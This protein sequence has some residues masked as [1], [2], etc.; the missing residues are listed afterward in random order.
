MYKSFACIVVIFTIALL[1]CNSTPDTVAV[2][3]HG[4]LYYIC[5]VEADEEYGY[6]NI[7]VQIKKFDEEGEVVLL[8]PGQVQLDN[9]PLLLDSARL[10]G[11][12]Y[13]IRKSIE[14]FTNKHTL[15]ITR[16]NGKKYS[17]TFEWSPLLLDV[18]LSGAVTRGSLILPLRGVKENDQI[19]LNLID[20]SFRTPDINDAFLVHNGQIQV[21][22]EVLSKVANGPVTLELHKENEQ[23]TDDTSNIKGVIQSI[24]SLRREFDLID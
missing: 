7:W 10:S 21:G 14:N 4:P 17:E 18:D 24:Y 6:V 2:R 5:K 22:K 20:T 11:A 3:D 9:E 15:V 16:N 23:K 8:D 12:F 13:E 19:R 1:A